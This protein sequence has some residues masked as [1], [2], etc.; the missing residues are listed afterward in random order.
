MSLVDSSIQVRRGNVYLTVS[1]NEI[2]KY[3]AK[4]FDVVDANGNVLK[5]SVPRDLGTL[6]KAY[7]TKEN[8]IKELKAEIKRLK[9]QLEEAKQQQ[10]QPKKSKKSE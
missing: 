10:A 1:S 4:G 3:I 6:Q 2:D 8:E 9:A 7:L 5:A